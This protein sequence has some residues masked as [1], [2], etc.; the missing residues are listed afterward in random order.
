MTKDHLKTTSRRKLG[1]TFQIIILIFLRKINIRRH[2]VNGSFKEYIYF[3]SSSKKLQNIS[4][5]SNI[6]TSKKP[7]KI[8][9]KLDFK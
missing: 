8:F 5:G 4:I 3:S 9:K 2:L 1:L 7:L 6:V